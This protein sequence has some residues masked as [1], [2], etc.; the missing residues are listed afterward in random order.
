MRRLSDR[1]AEAARGCTDLPQLGT[2]LG[3]VTREL[4]FHY[5]ALL[6][7]ASL[8]APSSGLV[9]IDNYPE[10]WVEEIVSRGFVVDDPVHLASRRTNA[11]F[12]WSELGNLIRLEQRHMRILAR[13][14]HHGLGEG[15]TVPANVPGEPSASCS[16]AV[17][18]G[19]DT[20]AAQLHCAELI[21]AHALCAARGLRPAAS[22]KRPH[23]SRR[24]LQCLRL[25]ALGKTDWEIAHILGLSPHTAHQYVKRAR[26]AYDTVSRAQ[27]VAY[28]LRDAWISFEDAIPPNG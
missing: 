15:L 13:S 23:L 1:F 27:L 5:F 7:H 21:G 17:R 4:G 9:R 2:L 11:G 28:G 6:D 10:D 25:V 3:D 18:A 26:A 22:R 8:G 12:G 14:R 19:L 24:E 16:F 20:P